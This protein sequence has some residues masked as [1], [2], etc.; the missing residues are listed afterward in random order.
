M[1]VEGKLRLADANAHRRVTNLLSPFHVVTHRQKNLFFDGA[2]SE[3]S[4]RCAVLC[5][6]FYGDDE[7]CIV[8]LKARA[9]LVGSVSRVDK[10][11]EDL[12]PCEQRRMRMCCRAWKVGIGGI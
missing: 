2:A 8:S 5:L 1:E 9:V 3:L 6:R 4:E 10:D 11:E 12:D 7:R